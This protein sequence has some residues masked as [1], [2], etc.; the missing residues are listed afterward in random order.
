MQPIFENADER[1][2]GGR[3]DSMGTVIYT[4]RISGCVEGEYTRGFVN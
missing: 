4:R 3:T 2:N 1:N